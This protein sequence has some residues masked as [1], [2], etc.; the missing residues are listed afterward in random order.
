IRNA[1]EK[2]MIFYGALTPIIYTSV[3]ESGVLLTI[4]YLVEPRQRRKTEQ[5]IWEATLEA[6]EKE[7]DIEL[8]YPT[9]RFYSTN[10]NDRI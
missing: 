1:A 6:F 7:K 5:Q 4:R 10:G 8:A 2:Y 3:K 9:T